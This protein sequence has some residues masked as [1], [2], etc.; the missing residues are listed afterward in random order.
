MPRE[1]SDTIYVTL[2]TGQRYE[3]RRVQCFFSNVHAQRVA[4]LSKGAQVTVRGR[5][6]GLMMNVQ[7]N[8]CEFVGM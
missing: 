2:G 1:K 8:D 7:M 6:D 5:V 4:S 3:P